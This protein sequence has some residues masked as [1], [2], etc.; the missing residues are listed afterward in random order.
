MGSANL[1]N[2]ALT[3]HY[4]FIDGLR[5]VA[6]ALVTLFHFQL[7][8]LNGGFLGVDVFFVI[9]GFVITE[10]IQK[11]RESGT[12]SVIHFWRRRVL[13]IIPALYATTLM[14]VIIA[15]LVY[16]PEDFQQNVQSA[17]TSLFFYSNFHFFNLTD[18]FSNDQ[19]F[20]LFLHHWS[21]SVEEQFYI[22][23][24]FYI[25]LI[26][27]F[28]NF[29]FPLIVLFLMATLFC[30]FWYYQSSSMKAFY[31]LPARA[32]EFLVGSALAFIPKRHFLNHKQSS[33]ISGA[34]LFLIL[35]ASFGV[36]PTVNV[37]QLDLFFA[38]LGTGLIISGCLFGVE[39]SIGSFLSLPPLRFLG[40]ISFSLYL[41]HWP[42]YVFAQYIAIDPLSPLTRIA[43][44]FPT[45]GIAWIFWKTVEVPFRGDV[46]SRALDGIKLWLWLLIATGLLF[47][48][49]SYIVTHKTKFFTPSPAV[50]G[51]LQGRLDFNPK[52]S[53]CHS[54]EQYRPVDPEKA[55]SFGSTSKPT[56]AVWG[57]SH[58]AEL[59]VALGNRAGQHNESV[60]QLSS[61]SCPPAIG[62]E[63]IVKP[64]CR[65][66][67]DVVLSYLQQHAEIDTVVLAMLYGGY[68]QHSD[69]SLLAGIEKVSQALAVARKRVIIIGPF[70]RP[71]FNVPHGRARAIYFNRDMTDGVP[72]ETH[73]LMFVNT[74]A[75]LRQIGATSGATVLD[76]AAVMCTQTTCSWIDKD[77]PLYFDDNHPSV[78][79]ASKVAEM[80]VLT[81]LGA[82]YGRQQK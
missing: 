13:R 34:G 29:R 40:R 39:N 61:S 7:L 8:N 33:A 1:S 82:G 60:L 24:P 59:A 80:L 41:V 57:D 36:L 51:A 16:L 43:L 63:F 10:M 38:V 70:P 81:P 31:L 69:K 75:T 74:M 50:L 26:Y 76:P 21:L 6:V 22:L 47:G 62:L 79:G 25:A 9:S 15:A 35:I 67:N 20:W 78:Y 77:R 55:C 27:R 73:R 28:W 54:D 72:A 58:A 30:Y 66:R 68:P 17:K 53:I 4:D 64:N 71:K 37:G 56:M 14:T 45:F 2:A 48:S 18:Y 23:F 19:N 52:R 3:D 49:F 46:V 12:Y 42:V 44:L 32:W 11:T 5:A 65:R